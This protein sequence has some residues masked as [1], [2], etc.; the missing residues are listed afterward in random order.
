MTLR[1]PL[2]SDRYG[3]RFSGGLFEGD[4]LHAQL[5][6]ALRERAQV[7]FTVTFFVVILP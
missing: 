3:S 7:A 2:P 4:H 6:G 1:K 5:G